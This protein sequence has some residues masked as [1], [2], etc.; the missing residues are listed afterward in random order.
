[1][2]F[3]LAICQP[4]RLDGELRKATVYPSL[5]L[6]LLRRE[7]RP[8]PL[9]SERS[10]LNIQNQNYYRRRSFGSYPFAKTQREENGTSLSPKVWWRCQCRPPCSDFSLVSPPPHHPNQLQYRER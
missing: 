3:Q 9:H 2:S 1:M 5:A 7:A 10:N 6:C 4:N 8:N